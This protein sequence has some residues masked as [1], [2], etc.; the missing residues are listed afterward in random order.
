MEPAPSPELESFA[1]PKRLRNSAGIDVLTRRAA[2]SSFVAAP[3][4]ASRTGRSSGRNQTTSPSSPGPGF[5]TARALRSSVLSVETRVV[6]PGDVIV[7]PPFVPS[8]CDGRRLGR[9]LGLPEPEP[10]VQPR[11]GRELVLE[12][13]VGA[14]VEEEGA[15]LRPPRHEEERLLP[16]LDEGAEPLLGDGDLP[17][18]R[19]E[20]AVPFRG[21]ARGEKGP[22]VER[23]APGGRLGAARPLAP[24]ELG[25]LRLQGVEAR[26]EPRLGPARPGLAREDVER[27]RH[28]PRHEQE[29]EDAD[30]EVG[31][32]EPAAD[33]PEEAAQ[34]VAEGADAEDRRRDDDREDPDDLHQ[35]GES[36]LRRRGWRGGSRRGARGPRP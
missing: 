3:V 6:L 28:E 22:S 2:P 21:A 12:R 30:E 5:F 16:V 23:A 27:G 1:S 20:R 4:A 11:F 19:A 32:E 24:R 25:R 34:E 13:G 33:P 7:T 10:D 36:R 35:L 9:R 29:R 15:R 26:E 18:L 31:D 17:E 14:A 8:T